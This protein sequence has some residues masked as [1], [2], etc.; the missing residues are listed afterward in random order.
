M[1][2]S[3][4]AVLVG[5]VLACSHDTSDEADE[6]FITRIDIMYLFGLSMAILAT[7]SIALRNVMEEIIFADY[8]KLDPLLF[9]A[10]YGLFGTG[11]IGTMLLAAQFVPGS[12]NGVQ[13][14]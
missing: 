12:D 7:M 13:V 11:L 8:K 5:T 10:S 6:M 2:V 9:S 4:L 1:M 14:L 3:I